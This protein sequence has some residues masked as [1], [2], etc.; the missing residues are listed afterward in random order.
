MNTQRILFSYSPSFLLA[1]LFVGCFSGSSTKD[2]ADGDWNRKGDRE[3]VTTWSVDG[4][5]LLEVTLDYVG[6]QPSLPFDG[7]K[8]TFDW[9]SRNTDF[10]ACTLRNLTD[11]PIELS[12]IHF[13][14]DRG[15]WKK[16]NPEDISYL[17]SRWGASRI[18]PNGS[19]KRRNTWVWGK[20]DNNVLRKTFRAE[21]VAGTTTSPKLKNLIE[22]KGGE[23]LSFSFQAPLKFIR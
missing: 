12:S 3:Y 16:K 9:N 23:A 20:G 21:I 8:P 6:K 17:V 19:L 15:T 14:L 13:A 10:Y 22:A 2:L 7:P 1:L 18:L 5:P 4:V 11:L